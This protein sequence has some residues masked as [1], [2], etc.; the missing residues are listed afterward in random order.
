[1][2]TAYAIAPSDQATAHENLA[3]TDLVARAAEGDM[4]AW[5]ALVDRFTPLIRS[6]CRRH[7]L[8]DADASDVAQSVWLRLVD[9]LGTIRDPA[10]LPGWLATTARREC[11]KVLRVTQGPLAGYPLQF[12]IADEHAGPVDTR[13]L[14]AERHAALREAFT[15]LPPGGQQLI[16]MLVADP[17]LPYTEISAKL[18]IPIGSIGPNRQRCMDKLRRY[19]AIA[20]LIS[21]DD[22]PRQRPLQPAH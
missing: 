21:A 5:D 10:A 6:V 19:P 2:M 9:R 3:V 1:M 12:E 17:P 7:R 14:A 15:A 13:L 16:T 20:A 11:L 8:G 22:G 18:G 4:Q